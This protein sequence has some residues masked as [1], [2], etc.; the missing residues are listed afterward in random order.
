MGKKEVKSLTNEALAKEYNCTSRQI[1]K[2]RRRGYITDNDGK[3]IM[4]KAPKPVLTGG[5]R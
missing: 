3:K 4:F 1:S 2:S 5:N